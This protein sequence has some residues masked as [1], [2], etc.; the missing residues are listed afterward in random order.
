MIDWLLQ[1]IENSL[2]HIAEAGG[3]TA[4]TSNHKA[5]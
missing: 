5:N 3:V 2:S 4:H 1:A